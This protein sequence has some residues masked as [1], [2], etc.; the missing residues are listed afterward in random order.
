M[1][2]PSPIP[3]RPLVL[4]LKLACAGWLLAGAAVAQTGVPVPAAQRFDVPAGPLGQTLRQF[5]DQAGIL[6][7]SDARLTQ[8]KRGPGLHAVATPVQGLQ[9]LLDGSGLVALPQADGSFVLRGEA[10][11][12]RDAMT[13]VP[14]AEV[15]V[16]GERPTQANGS[17]RP[18]PSKSALHSD[19]DMLDAPQVL[20]V[21]PAQV[22]VD[23][24]PRNIDDALA[25]VSGIT[26][27]NTLAGTQDTIMKR[28]FGGN[29][30][31]S[32]MHNGM[33][34]V[35]G[36]G[37]NAAAESVEVLKGPSSLLYGIMDP[38]GVI[39]VV[40][41]KPLR[42]RSTSLA[43]LASTYGSGKNGSGITFDTTGPVGE[44]GLSYRVIADHV[45]EDYWRNF[46]THRETLFAPSLAWSARDMRLLLSY[47][48]REFLYPFDRGTALDPR[49]NLPLD[50]PITRRLDELF[51]FMKG[52]SDLVQFTIDQQLS[53][54]WKAH[55]G[56]GYNSETYDANQLRVNG[57][58]TRTATLVCSNDATHGA[59][60]TDSYGLFYLQG[61][62]H[63]AGMRHEAQI[64]SD[65]EYRRIFRSDLLCQATKTVFSYLN[66][67]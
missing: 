23:Q 27:G 67:L 24:R 12:P 31:G 19:V 17:Y 35:Q 55:V 13:G 42:E 21:V 60:S 52:K 11:P 49:T 46:G 38:G 20:N 44:S 25:N 65:I 56:L 14:V 50:I 63:L 66:P 2:V 15:I 36:R 48:H 28:G 62:L 4:S 61:S 58:N 16:L 37:M 57:V 26:Q 30:D 47:E 54:E 32:I 6:L 40:S 64:G 18:V 9:L 8:D 3:L 1:S 29:R 53:K 45:D 5:A 39:N 34:L 7:S 33:P 43:L 22:I 41:K 10:A 51:N 59:I